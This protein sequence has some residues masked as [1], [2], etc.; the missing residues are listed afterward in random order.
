MQEAQARIRK[1]FKNR[2][3]AEVFIASERA[4]VYN[5]LLGLDMKGVYRNVSSPTDSGS[6]MFGG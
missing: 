2:K 6:K 3:G 4:K 1:S 5:R